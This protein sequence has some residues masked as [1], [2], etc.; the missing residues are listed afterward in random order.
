MQLKTITGW[1]SVAGLAAAAEYDYIIVGGGPSGIIA[2]ERLTA[3]NNSVLLLERGVCALLCF[4]HNGNKTN[5][6]LTSW[7]SG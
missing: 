3:A 4:Q 5:K 7:M 2:A 1:L 6:G